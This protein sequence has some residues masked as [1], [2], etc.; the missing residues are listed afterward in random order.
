MVHY[1]PF[2]CLRIRKLCK[3]QLFMHTRVCC[4]SLQIQQKLY[5]KKS[6][7]QKEIILYPATGLLL[8]KFMPPATWRI[9]IGSSW[10]KSAAWSAWSTPSC[11]WAITTVCRA[12]TPRQHHLI[13]CSTC[14]P[15]TS[16]MSLQNLQGKYEDYSRVAQ[17]QSRPS[18]IYATVT[19]MI[20]MNPCLNSAKESPVLLILDKLLAWLPAAHWLHVSELVAPAKYRREFR[21]CEKFLLCFLPG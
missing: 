4:Q 6:I 14:L 19:W 9:G 10:A 5:Y 7:L 18:A 11:L 12:P 16:R 13:L 20:W 1:T 2:V 8:L 3:L 15:D 21:P 17:G